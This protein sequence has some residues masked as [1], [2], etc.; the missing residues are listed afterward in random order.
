MFI[1]NLKREYEIFKKANANIPEFKKENHWVA[2]RIIDLIARELLGNV[3]DEPS[4]KE[5]INKRRIVEDITEYDAWQSATFFTQRYKGLIDCSTFHKWSA[6]NED[7]YKKCLPIY[8]KNKLY[9][10]TKETWDYL[11]S[12]IMYRNRI[13]KLIDAGVISFNE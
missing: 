3:A 9:I 1:E 11:N 12:Q 6:N 8:Y 2:L 7:F 13:K 4:P 5:Q 10:H